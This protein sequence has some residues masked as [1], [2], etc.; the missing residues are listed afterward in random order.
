MI[1]FTTNPASPA[2]P[3]SKQTIEPQ[4]IE[5][6]SDQLK[7]SPL[8][9]QLQ[10]IQTLSEA[11]E[12]GIKPIMAFLLD[13]R[14]DSPTSSEGKA[15]QVLCKMRT[16]EVEA[17]LQTHFPT[18]LISTPSAQDLDYAPLQELL[19]AQDFEAA[20]RL[21]LQ[22]LCELAGPAAVKRKWLYFTEVEGFPS[23][24]LRTIDTLWSIYSENKFGFSKQREI[25]FSV[26]QNWESL[27]TKI[28]WKTNNNWTRYPNEFIWDLTAPSGHLPLSNQ[29]RGVRVMDS[30]L[31]H[32]AWKK[33]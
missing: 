30:L 23:L 8:K 2:D 15:Y 29:L 31:N 12:V 22:N 6:L 27:W 32:P 3:S 24:D 14:P 19:A 16:P 13:R 20:D 18:G 21:T 26:G 5:A 11:G 33:Q 7:S 28:A 25:W 9:K 1:S 17:F 10:I 4:T